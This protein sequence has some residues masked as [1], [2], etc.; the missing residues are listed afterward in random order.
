L[1]QLTSNTAA[2][3]ARRL[4][5]SRQHQAAANVSKQTGTYSVTPWSPVVQIP[6]VAYIDK[7]FPIPG[8]SRTNPVYNLALCFNSRHINIITLFTTR[9]LK[10]SFPLYVF[11]IRF[12]ACVYD[13]VDCPD[14]SVT[15]VPRLFRFLSGS[16]RPPLG[17][18]APSLL[19]N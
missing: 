15:I 14:S 3:F 5:A 8:V 19:F 18:D 6:T 10:W 11:H 17:W 2:G 9:F 16:K 1:C 4:S 13:L 12:V 7:T